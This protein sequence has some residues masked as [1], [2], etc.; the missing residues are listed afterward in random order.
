[1]IMVGPGTGIAPFRSFWQ[2]RMYQVETTRNSRMRYS[3]SAPVHKALSRLKKPDLPRSSSDQARPKSRRIT[4]QTRQ[5]ADS[6]LQN[7]DEGIPLVSR[8]RSASDSC[9]HGQIIHEML[10][11]S[12][13]F[14][15][16]YLFFGCRQSTLDHIY[17]DEMAKAC[18]F[19]AVEKCYVAL[20]REPNQSKVQCNAL[21]EQ[22]IAYVQS[23]QYSVYVQCICTV[24]PIQCICTVMPIQCIC[25]VMPIQCICTVMPIQCI[26]TVMPIQCI[27][28]VMPIQCIYT[29]MI[30]LS[31]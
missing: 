25:T 21:A 7:G 9:D 2:E 12:S 13:E 19:G 14:G 18:M 5:P 22:V 30:G 29:V 20:S 27:C 6:D 17:K 28:T 31:D 10:K 26:C 4:V 23:C 11:A 1:M 8:H 24:M 16:M 15:S 3:K